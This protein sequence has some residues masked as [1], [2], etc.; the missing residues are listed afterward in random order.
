MGGMMGLLDVVLNPMLEP[1]KQVAEKIFT[2]GIKVSP[3]IAS[4]RLKICKSCPYLLKRTGNCTKCGCFVD[5]KTM[6]QDQSC[7][8]GKW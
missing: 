3:E 2:N 8:I 1:L 7:K 5:V 6:Y 4:K